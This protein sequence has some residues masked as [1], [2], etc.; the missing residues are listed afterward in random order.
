[1][2]VE[3]VVVVLHNNHTR[4]LTSHCCQQHLYRSS[5][6]WHLSLSCVLPSDGVFWSSIVFWRS[7]FFR[8]RVIQTTCFFKIWPHLHQLQAFVMYGSHTPFR[9]NFPSGAMIIVSQLLNVVHVDVALFIWYHKYKHSAK[10][11]SLYVLP[12]LT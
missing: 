6:L 1:M 5:V 11:H 3:E 8:W 4:N 12:G 9:L 2:L 7:I 10:H